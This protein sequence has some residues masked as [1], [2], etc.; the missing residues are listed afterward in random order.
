MSLWK[1]YFYF[2]VPRRSCTKTS[3]RS[4][5]DG[6]IT[7]SINTGQTHSCWWASAPCL[8]CPRCYEEPGRY[9][10]C[11]TAVG[12][13]PPAAKNFSLTYSANIDSLPAPRQRASQTGPEAGGRASSQAGPAQP[14]AQPQR[15]EKV[16]AR[17][18]RGGGRLVLCSQ[19][20][21]WTPVSGRSCPVPQARVP[22]GLRALWGSWRCGSPGWGPGL[23]LCPAAQGTNSGGLG[24]ASA[25][26]PPQ[27]LHFCCLFGVRGRVAERVMG[28]AG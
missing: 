7:H 18:A 26:P 9:T 2:S 3:I 28:S 16:Q 23:S 20:V 24:S 1:C 6:A 19:P 12:S 25:C 13:F 22:A 10:H 5:R 15:P 4:I 27:S 17:R 14:D 11:V 8:A 21:N